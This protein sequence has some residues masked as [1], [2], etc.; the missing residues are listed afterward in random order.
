MNKVT[1]PKYGNAKQAEEW[2]LRLFVTDWAPRCIV[3]YRNLTRICQENIENRCNIEVVDILERP[4]A[5][6]EQQIVAVP[7]LL[8]LS[9]EPRRVLVGDF[10][11]TERVL[12]GLDVGRWTKG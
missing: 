1:G 12:K 10:S 6:R 8:K 5:A 3:A 2:K 7:T 9:P 11:N 4:E